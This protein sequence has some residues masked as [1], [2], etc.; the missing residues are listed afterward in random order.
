MRF[1]HLFG[2]TMKGDPSEAETP[3]HR[4]LL[5]AGMIAPLASGIYSYLPL[6]QRSL[7]RIHA[8]VH[9][10]M[11]AADGQE[12]KMPAL[13]P[14][15]LWDLSKRNKAFGSNL[16]RLQ[17]RRERPLVMAPTPE[18]VVSLLA[19]QFVHSYRD[20]PLLVYQIQTK[21]RDEP[22]PRGGLLRVREFDMKDAY[23]FDADEE[24]V[25]QSYQRMIKAYRNIFDRCGAPSILVEA[26]SGAIGG[27]D[28][29]EFIMPTESGED[30]V[31]LCPTCGYAAN[32][33]RAEGNPSPVV[34]EEPLPLEEV[35]TPGIKTIQGLADYLGI[36][37]S[38]TLKAVFYTAE[39][40]VVFVTLRGDLAVNEIKLRR[41]LGVHDLRL[42][43]DEEVK[44]AG[45]VAG[46]ASP[47][48]I[49]HIKRVGDPSITE[50]ANFVVGANRPDY[51]LRNANYPRDFQ[52]DVLADIALAEAGHRC[53]RCPEGVLE[54]RK[55]IE[56]GHVFKLGTSFSETFGAFYLDREGKQRPLIM[57]CYGIGMGRLL[58][59]TIEHNHD[60]RGILFPASITPYDVSLV[61]LNIEEPGVASAAEQLYERLQGVGLQVLFDDREESAGVKFNDADLLG[62]PARVVVSPR[63]L[64]QQGAEVK[65][66]RDSSAKLVPLDAVSSVVKELV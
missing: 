34:P 36:P 31:I 18:E 49:G 4:L 38:K 51:H 32:A 56:L 63:T 25:E 40:R 55:G 14:Q 44:D 27:K 64:R 52:M 20:L 1:R 24:G 58:A 61:A 54:A 6:A 5:K 29:H 53:K 39:G 35:H 47:I 10:E 57:G 66:R 9:E 21:F 43:T 26:D 2:H 33:E 42:A 19:R 17:D 3:S 62:F 16:L 37:Q 46:S 23:S 30:T 50:G 59:A 11:Q 12:I 8:I 7:R 13:Q 15:D 41:V 60:E 22:R 45:L 48:N 28:S 65:R